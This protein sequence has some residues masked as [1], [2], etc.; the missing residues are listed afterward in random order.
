MRVFWHILPPDESV[1]FLFRQFAAYDDF[2]FCRVAYLRPAFFP[3]LP[4]CLVLGLGPVFRRGWSLVLVFGVGSFCCVFGVGPVFSGLGS[5]C[6]RRGAA[7]FLVLVRVGFCS[8]FSGCGVSLSWVWR[9]FSLCV[10]FFFFSLGV[11]CL[12]AVLFCFLFG[13]GGASFL[14]CRPQICEVTHLTTNLPVVVH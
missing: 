14:L 13:V 1:A 6:F 8:C 12:R 11:G 10:V 5:L 4:P 7:A 2:V 3:L 9:F